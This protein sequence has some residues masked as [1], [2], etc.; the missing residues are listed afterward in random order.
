MRLK[1]WIKEGLKNTAIILGACVL[2]TVLLDV[3]DA[4]EDL[5][6][7]FNIGAVYLLLFGSMFSMVLNTTA[8]QTYIPLSLGFGST[9]KEVLLGL[10]CY[11]MIPTVILLPI[12]VILFALSDASSFEPWILFTAGLGLF[13]V[14]HGLGIL[15]GVLFN[16]FG[17]TGLIAFSVII[18]IIIIG[19]FIGVIT[20]LDIEITFPEGMPW[21]VLGTGALF[22]GL[23]MLAEVRTVKKF[24]VKL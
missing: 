11:R 17:K 8:Y 18:C 1:F 4:A 24:N 16:R 3:Q 14:F 12:T 15:M 9:R 23:M 2:Y 10:Q 13:L 21:I 19:F 22:Y 6:G 20:A 7:F 5:S